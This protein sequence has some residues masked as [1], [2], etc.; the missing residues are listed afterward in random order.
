MEEGERQIIQFY[1]L[2]RPCM[3]SY[4]NIGIYF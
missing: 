3:I 1:A 2:L 4:D